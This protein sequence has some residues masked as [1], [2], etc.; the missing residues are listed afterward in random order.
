MIS[1]CNQTEWN[2]IEQQSL[3]WPR[4]SNKCGNPFL[5]DLV[6]SQFNLQCPGSSLVYCSSNLHFT[7]WWWWWWQTIPKY[8]RSIEFIR[9]V[10][11]FF[12]IYS[13]FYLHFFRCFVSSLLLLLYSINC[14]C[15]CVCL[16]SL[17]FALLEHFYTNF[18]HDSYIIWTA[19]MERSIRIHCFGSI[20]MNSYNGIIGRE[21]HV[22]NWLIMESRIWYVKWYLVNVD[23][24]HAKNVQTRKSE[25]EI[26]CD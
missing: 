3:T 19:W 16:L 17:I 21:M 8:I 22:K 9:F 24:Y 10:N 26:R 14:V 5:W 25:R 15:V 12:F 20:W 7:P 18:S 23:M 11:F 4:N 2:G 1:S 6:P 13:T